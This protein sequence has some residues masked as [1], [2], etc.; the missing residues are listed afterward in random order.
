MR[1]P[2]AVVVRGGN[3][4]IG[5]E[6]YRALYIDAAAAYQLVAHCSIFADTSDADKAGDGGDYGSKSGYYDQLGYEIQTLM[7]HC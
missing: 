5:S 6:N 3:S 2:V 7:L 1:D 4:A